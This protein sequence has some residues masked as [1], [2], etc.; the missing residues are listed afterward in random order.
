MQRF[1]L[2][3]HRTQRPHSSDG[4]GRSSSRHS[5]RSNKSSSGKTKKTGSKISRL[6]SS[7]GDTLKS[8]LF[9]K[10]SRTSSSS[11][12]GS[13]GRRVQFQDNASMCSHSGS[14]DY[15]ARE[16]LRRTCSGGVPKLDQVQREQLCADVRE[17]K[18]AMCGNKKT[19]LSQ[20]TVAQVEEDVQNKYCD[21]KGK[22]NPPQTGQ[23]KGESN[24]APSSPKG[25]PTPMTPLIVNLRQKLQ[26][27]KLQH[28][29]SLEASLRAAE[30]TVS[31]PGSP[32]RPPTPEE[33]DTKA[34]LAGWL[35]E[36]CPP[37]PPPGTNQDPTETIPEP[38]SPYETL[39][40]EEQHIL[41]LMRLE[42]LKKEVWRN[43][44]PEY[45]SAD[46]PLPVGR[47]DTK[48]EPRKRVAPRP[49]YPGP[50]KPAQTQ[51]E[52]PEQQRSPTRKRSPSRSPDRSPDRSPRRSPRRSPSPTRPPPPPTFRK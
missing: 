6:A 28:E 51:P 42:Q 20:K 23:N 43:G 32:P 36:L 34:M 49:P 48:D 7:V 52:D 3:P 37:N 26:E 11:S 21:G 17:V 38:R 25:T 39:S 50:R 1:S 19:A 9:R 47:I 27:Y 2:Q 31:K 15:Q 30:T 41:H 18:E 33:R 22:T 5:S 13:S 16:L 10:V 29:A 46:Y 44:R 45:N 24:A 12:H 8:A 40:A 35:L 14:T 4:S